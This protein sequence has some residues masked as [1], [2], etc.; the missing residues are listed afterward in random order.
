MNWNILAYSILLINCTSTYELVFFLS[1]EKGLSGVSLN[2]LIMVKKEN[3]KSFEFIRSSQMI[4][5]WFSLKPLCWKE[6]RKKTNCCVRWYKLKVELYI[7][8]SIQ[9][10]SCSCLK[11]SKQSK[12]TKKIHNQIDLDAIEVTTTEKY[13]T[14]NFSWIGFM[15]NVSH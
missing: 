14:Q 1:F 7:I 15:K 6:F 10:D 5:I 9:Y 8:R 12:Q 13:K 4:L 11:K 3:L 2:P